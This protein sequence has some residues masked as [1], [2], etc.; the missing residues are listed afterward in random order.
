[1]GKDSFGIFDITNQSKNIVRI[2]GIHAEVKIIDMICEVTVYQFFYSLEETKNCVYL[3][4]L[5]ANSAVCSFDTMIG[6]R[7]LSA[8][9]E[10]KEVAT[11]R[12]YF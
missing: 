1:M 8:H 9:I 2:D 6:D 12:F 5:D 3:F 4:P 11:Q 10:D 7:F